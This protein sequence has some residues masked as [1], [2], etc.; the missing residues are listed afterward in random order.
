M[1]LCGKNSHWI[2][3]FGAIDRSALFK[4]MRFYVSANTF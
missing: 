3:P 4:K 1:C 2:Q